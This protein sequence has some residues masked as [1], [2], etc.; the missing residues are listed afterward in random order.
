[1][2]RRKV[3]VVTGSRADYGI[4]YWL[5][6]DID[7]DP[8]M[9]LQLVVTGTH[10]EARFG[11]TVELIERDGLAI[12]ERV[13]MALEG[14]S[15][16][17]VARSMGRVTMGMADALD[18]L[19]P[20][21]LVL[22][23]DRYEILAT[24][25]AGL[26]LG[27]PIAHIHGGE[28][29]A[30]AFD[31]SIRHAVTKM[32]HLHFTAAEPYRR[33]V[34]QLG[35]R[36]DRV[37]AVGAPGLDNVCRLPLLERGDLEREIGRSL[38]AAYFLVTYHPVTVSRSSDVQVADALV[39]ALGMFPEHHVLF[40]GVNADP[41]HDRIAGRFAT[42]AETEPDR[43]FVYASLGQRTYLSALMHASAVIGNSSSGLIEAPALKVPTVN[44][45]PRQAGRLRSTS[46]IDCGE[47][48]DEIRAAIERALS[49]A[50][51]RTLDGATSPYGEPGASRRIKE[52]LRTIDLDGLLDK[53]FHDIATVH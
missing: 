46:V 52:T 31:D 21:I 12:R 39:D 15:R 41:G 40:T 6:R 33:R 37:F 43:V 44:I 18:R 38:G 36:P 25:Q 9:E 4:L 48:R 26:I 19:R 2:S 24:A 16:A 13:P 30:G 53:G 7:D 45:G 47:D 20:D 27:I 34:V 5:M 49:A 17:A 29:T 8:A 23:G 11:M 32:A 14:D 22:L 10:L 35:E 50:F 3:C 1:M 51:R 28:I 42:F